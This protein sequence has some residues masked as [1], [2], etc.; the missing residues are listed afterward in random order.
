VSVVGD[1]AAV[2]LGPGGPTAPQLAQVAIQSGRHAAKQ[3]V[4]RR[5]SMETLGF[6]YRDKGQMAT[7]GRRAAVAQLRHGPVIR[8]VLGWGAW[9]GLHLVYLMGFR[10]RVLVL[11]N[12]T[13][14]YF[15]WPS[16]PRLIITGP[17]PDSAAAR[18]APP[19][20]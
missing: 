6:H 17:T 3:I 14:R 19:A 4:R 5:L 9:L 20:N 2:P 18:T 15:D 13:W 16:G 11:V 1:A 12:W 10:N 7:I 8:G